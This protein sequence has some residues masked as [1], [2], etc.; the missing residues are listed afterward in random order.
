[1]NSACA[2]SAT[3]LA[4]TLG[5][6][7]TAGTFTS[8][9]GLTINATTGAVNP[10]TSTA[11]TYTVTNTVAAANGCAAA[12]TTATVTINAL[13]TT[14]TYTYT[15]PTRSTVLFTS[16]L[17]PAGTTYQWYLNGVAITGATSQTYTANGTTSPG[18]YTVRF[19]STATGCSSAASVALTVTATNQALAG[20]SLHLFPNP[21]AT[22]LLTL[23]LTGYTKAVEL[24]VLDALGRVVLTQKVAAGQVQT[25]LDLSGAATGVYLLRATTEGGTDV[26]RIVRE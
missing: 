9:T 26:R 5:T 19:I 8:T 23:Q 24:T 7:A 12:T 15:Y 2:G 3:L 16:S 10:A 1:M 21:T 25:Q 17:A 22:G 18:A 6:G 11:G 14:P 20:T 4:A 13:P